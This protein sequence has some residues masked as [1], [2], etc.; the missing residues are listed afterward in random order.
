M[1]RAFGRFGNIRENLQLSKQHF[2]PF[3]LYREAA[4]DDFIRGFT[5]Q[6]TEN[7]DRFFAH[8]VKKKILPGGLNFSNISISFLFCV[9][10]FVLG[11]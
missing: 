4:I 3:S 1:Y 6:N 9:L 10:F 8:E 2:A 5:F 7:F 11:N